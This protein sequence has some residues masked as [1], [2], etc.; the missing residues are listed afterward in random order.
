MFNRL[1]DI[2]MGTIALFLAI[3]FVAIVARENEPLPSP[4]T[5]GS[6]PP[7][8]RQWPEGHNWHEEPDPH[9]YDPGYQRDHP[10]VS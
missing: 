6:S 5:D 1:L 2:L 4:S 10:W 9:P 7:V 3:A 8:I